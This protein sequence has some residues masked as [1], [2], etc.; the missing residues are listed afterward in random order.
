[1]TVPP[2]AADPDIGPQRSALPLI[3][4]LDGTLIHG[5]LLHET[6]K[7]C[8]RHHP[9]RTAFAFPGA[10]FAGR[11]AV[12]RRLA[13]IRQPDINSIAFN[14]D[15]IRMAKAVHRE[16]RDV[17]IATA[18][19]ATLANLVAARVGFIAGVLASDGV[20]N[21]K[22]SAKARTLSARFP[23]GFEYAGDSRADLAVW[24]VAA[25]AYVV[26]PG[27]WLERALRK[28]GVPVEIVGDGAKG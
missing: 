22:G 4:D 2:S 21:L 27:A 7:A 5:D 26:A 20:L 11:A 24:R 6:V 18:A 25:K 17:W 3:L 10:V 13:A 12:K 9:V 19:E 14:A 28:L 1:L 23:G 8:L 15:V 16:G